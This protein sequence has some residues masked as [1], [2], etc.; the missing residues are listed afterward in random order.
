MTNFTKTAYVIQKDERPPK[1]S[2]EKSYIR[3]I[4]SIYR[5]GKNLSKHNYKN[6]K[7]NTNIKEKKYSSSFI[8]I[9]VTQ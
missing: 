3:T 4:S 2:N 9:S 1:H 6:T 7:K 5:E 8:R